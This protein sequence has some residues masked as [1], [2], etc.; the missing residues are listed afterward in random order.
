MMGEDIPA[1]TSA[2]TSPSGDIVEQLNNSC[3]A[4]SSMVVSGAAI[5]PLKYDIQCF[6]DIYPQMILVPYGSLDEKLT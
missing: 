2:R 4:W 6:R 1:F 3:L 5:S